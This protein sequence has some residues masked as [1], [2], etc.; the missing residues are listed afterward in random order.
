MRNRLDELHRLSAVGAQGRSGCIGQHKQRLRSLRR[1]HFDPNQNGTL[2]DGD[3]PYLKEMQRARDELELRLAVPS[4]Q[5][6]P[7]RSNAEPLN[8]KQKPAST[9]RRMATSQEKGRRRRPHS[10]ETVARS[11]PDCRKPLRHFSFHRGTGRRAGT[12]PS[13]TMD[14]PPVS[15]VE[16]QLT[17]CLNAPSRAFLLPARPTPRIFVSDRP[18][19]RMRLAASTFSC[20]S[21]R[22]RAVTAV[23][24]VLKCGLSQPP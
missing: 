18:L 20:T 13:P 15:R 16:R 23:P 12:R 9:W 8:N 5:K 17:H 10:G 14:R 22:D 7:S 21:V 3:A 19:Q 1:G 2:S 6:N 4:I 11:P 24:H